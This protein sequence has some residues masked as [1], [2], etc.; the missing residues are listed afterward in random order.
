MGRSA[1]L[2][3]GKPKKCTNRMAAADEQGGL[4][5]ASKKRTV[6][7]STYSTFG[8]I[9]ASLSSVT[10]AVA[11]VLSGSVSTVSTVTCRVVSGAT[12]ITTRPR[13]FY[14]VCSVSDL[15]ALGSATVVGY[16]DGSRYP[17][18]R[19]STPWFVNHTAGSGADNSGTFT[20]VMTTGTIATTVSEFNIR[21]N[22]PQ[23]GLSRLPVQY[24][25]DNLNA[26]ASMSNRSFALSNSVYTITANR[27]N[28]SGGTQAA[29]PILLAFS[30]EP[31]FQYTGVTQ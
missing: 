14:G 3:L 1:E 28:L 27:R 10:S 25:L 9:S 13:L 29:G 23:W 15:T 26:P 5:Y 7:Q 20:V 16:L 31:P 22:I 8:T 11:Q 18:Y 17:A 21:A 19:V 30:M 6:V 2:I 24:N 4:F 12:T